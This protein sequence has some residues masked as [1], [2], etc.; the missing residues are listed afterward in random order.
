MNSRRLNADKNPESETQ[1]PAHDP[2]SY[3]EV[4]ADT[5]LP[6]SKKEAPA[7]PGKEKPNF[8]LSGQSRQWAR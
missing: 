8:S 7:N 4:G 2:G 5:N 1:K 3:P 6:L